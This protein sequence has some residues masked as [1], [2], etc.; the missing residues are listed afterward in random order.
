MPTKR[1]VLG[2]AGFIALIISVLISAC[3]TSPTPRPTDNP[4]TLTAKAASP[5]PVA[6]SP[7]A[8]PTDTPAPSATP[9]PCTALNLTPEECANQGTHQYSITYEEL[10]G[11]ETTGEDHIGQWTNN[12]DQGGIDKGDSRAIR[13]EPNTYLWHIPDRPAEATTVLIFSLDGFVLD[14]Y[15]EEVLCVH[16]TYELVQ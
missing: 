2:R 10:N 8:L 13:Q 11:C 7:T 15:W 9:D 4:V 14:E 12:F 1:F 16:T 6:P 3:V 5:T